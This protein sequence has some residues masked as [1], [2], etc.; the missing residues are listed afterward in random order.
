MGCLLVWGGAS[1]LPLTNRDAAI[2][3]F[4]ET[5]R[6]KELARDAGVLAP[7]PSTIFKYTMPDRVYARS[8]E[9]GPASNP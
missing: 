3:T 4:M 8:P 7:G 6:P 1:K 5:T 9:F 2:N